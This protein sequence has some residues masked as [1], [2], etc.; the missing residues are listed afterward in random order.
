[1]SWYWF[2]IAFRLNKDTVNTEELVKVSPNIQIL[3]TWPRQDLRLARRESKCPIRRAQIT[4]NHSRNRRFKAQDHSSSQWRG[5]PQISPNRG[6]KYT[7]PL[8]LSSP[9]ATQNTL[10]SKIEIYSTYKLLNTEIRSDLTS[11]QT[12]LRTQ[13]KEE[14]ALRLQNEHLEKILKER[15]EE[16]QNLM[17]SIKLA[18]QLVNAHE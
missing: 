9:I 16:N 5:R 6:Q 14:S 1:M 17:E 7:P 18:E 13:E 12:E 3:A 8:P 10:K 4:W 2:I 15:E 11:K